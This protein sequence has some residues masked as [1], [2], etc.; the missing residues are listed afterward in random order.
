MNKQHI[1]ETLERHNNIELTQ[2][3]DEQKLVANKCD[4]TKEFIGIVEGI[5]KER[6]DKV[7]EILNDFI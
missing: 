2:M 3:L 4:E 5:I 7:D 1:R 6:Q